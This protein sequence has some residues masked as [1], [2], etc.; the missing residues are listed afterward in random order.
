[1]PATTVT[2]HPNGSE[3]H[4]EEEAHRY[5]M[6]GKEI[7]FTSV[8]SL[9]NANFPKFETDKVALKVV[10]KEFRVKNQHPT[11]AELSARVTALLAEWD[12]KRDVACD[13]GTRVHENCEAQLLNL[14]IPNP[15]KNEKE[16]KVMALAVEE[17]RKLQQK[18][19][20]YGCE[21]VLFSE[22]LALAGTI[23]LL[24]W[25][26]ETES[27]LILDWKTNAKISIENRWQSGLG[28]LAHLEDSSYNHYALQ[29]SVY[30]HLLISEG[31][32]PPDTKFVR[33]LIHIH[34]QS[35]VKY[36]DLPFFGREVINI[37]SLN[38][39]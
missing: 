21:S 24:M 14:P 29:L 4:F 26:A 5:F 10:Q 16:T 32:F 38:N 27:V 34:E 23:D 2:K 9:V 39:Q 33:R 7:K 25:D 31:Y 12:L 37:I 19:H 35:G 17:V 11:E 1:M 15:A 3:I 13:Y 28:P 18:F 22:K 36:Y 8:T 30:Q 20:F 6:P